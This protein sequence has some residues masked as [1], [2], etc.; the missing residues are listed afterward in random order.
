MASLLDV[1]LYE[2]REPQMLLPLKQLVMIKEK[3]CKALYLVAEGINTQKV[4]SIV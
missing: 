3:K 1:A 2:S 4:P